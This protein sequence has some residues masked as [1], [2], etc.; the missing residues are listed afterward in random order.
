[1]LGRAGVIRLSRDDAVMGG[2]GITEGVE[3]GL[4]GWSP[5]ECR[6]DQ[7][8]WALEGIVEGSTVC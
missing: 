4:A 3:D 1:M 6:C 7:A 2:L 8:M 5:I